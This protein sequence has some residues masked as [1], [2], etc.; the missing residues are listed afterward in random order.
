M[1]SKNQVST[2]SYP[3]FMWIVL[4][5]TVALVRYVIERKEN[6]RPAKFVRV[7]MHWR[8]Y[9]Y[10]YDQI[11]VCLIGALRSITYD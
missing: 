2:I 6:L 3:R 11:P 5:I 10:S 8:H 1:F 9:A 7:G 4:W